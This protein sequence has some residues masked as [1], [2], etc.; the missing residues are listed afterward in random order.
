MEAALNALHCATQ[1]C[2]ASAET[3]Q[4]GMQMQSS[5]VQELSKGIIFLFSMS[6]LWLK[7]GPQRRPDGETIVAWLRDSQK[8]RY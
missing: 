3:A 2:Q 6:C 8:C 1:V 7:C 4:V 5:T